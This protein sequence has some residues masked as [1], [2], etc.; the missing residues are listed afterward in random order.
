MEPEYPS[1][2]YDKATAWA[3]RGWSPAK[4]SYIALL[5]NFQN[6]S[7]PTHLPT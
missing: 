4:A 5:H 1:R 6:R 2:Y 3:V 7:G